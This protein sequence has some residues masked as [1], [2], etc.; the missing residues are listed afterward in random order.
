M[1]GIGFKSKFTHNIN[2][3]FA[4]KTV[5]GILETVSRDLNLTYKICSVNSWGTIKTKILEKHSNRMN[6]ITHVAS[7]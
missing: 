2:F 3:V 5:N 1:S 6:H 7:N 4:C